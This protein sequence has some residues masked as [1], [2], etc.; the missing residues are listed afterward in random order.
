[1][2]EF[3]VAGEFHSLILL[4]DGVVLACGYS[5]NWQTDLPDCGGRHAVPGRRVTAATGS[6]AKY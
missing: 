2:I 6:K 1:M 5:A 3:F 4:E